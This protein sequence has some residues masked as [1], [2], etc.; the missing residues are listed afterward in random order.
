MTFGITEHK[1]GK[2]FRGASSA[3]TGIGTSVVEAVCKRKVVHAD[4][5][6]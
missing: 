3:Q 2:I 5:I 1:R 4:S 6:T